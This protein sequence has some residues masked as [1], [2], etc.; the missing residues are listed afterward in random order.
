MPLAVLLTIA[1][2]LNAAAAM[3]VE[4][5]A[6]RLLAPYFGM[7]VYTWTTV[8]GVVLSG[9]SLGHW[10]GGRLADVLPQ[11]IVQRLRWAFA[12]SGAATL[13]ILPLL[14]ASA[15]Y[16]S[17]SG[18]AP[19]VAII[20][21]SVAAF[22]MPS[23]LA[24]LV[25]PL[26]TTLALA[27]SGHGHGRL[28]GRMLA[29]G[30]FG[31]IV[32]TFAAG[33]VLISYFGSTASLLGVAAV[34]FLLACAFVRSVLP[35][36][37][38]M[39]AATAIV[40]LCARYGEALGL[41]MGCTQESQYYC[42]RVAP[43]DAITGRPSRLIVMQDMFHSISD[44]DDPAMLHLPYQSFIEHLLNV[45]FPEAERRIF[46]LGGGGFTLPRALLWRDPAR[47]LTIAEL[48]PAVIE[49]AS[50]YMWF[51]PGP[52][53]R[54]IVGDGRVILT[55]LSAGERF[56]I[57]IADAYQGA[58]VP[59]HLVTLEFCRL[60]QARLRD[61]GVLLMNVI[62]G[63]SEPRLAPSVVATLS[64]IFSNVEVWIVPAEAAIRSRINYMVYAAEEPS[65]LPDEL[66][67]ATS[68]PQHWRRL[69]V[70]AQ[71]WQSSGMILSDDFAPI[72]R[73]L[74]EFWRPRK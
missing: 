34:D 40:G 61:G 69:P 21:S 33:F 53:T 14:H 3:I 32:G 1:V 29:A 57:I 70:S 58:D 36:T 37:A 28:V 24:G 38:L 23:F 63:T 54:V 73:L 72:D 51:E 7:S 6:G 15:A 74:A 17:R 46:I 20:A 71:R 56:D 16:A 22:F 31:S 60:V 43:A 4:I 10:V 13:V 41:R 52:N 26:A 5:I 8:I 64:E 47:R 35:R 25:Q 55:A 42:I 65:G 67:T 50:D 59:F 66:R 45:R 48:D 9:L 68:P 30:A 27:S 49:Q 11:R 18:V 2:M 39:V 19:A 12:A 62:D 44:R